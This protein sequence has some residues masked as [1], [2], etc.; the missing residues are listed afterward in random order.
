V[1]AN[2]SVSSG[3][4]HIWFPSDDTRGL[5]LGYK[6]LFSIVEINALYTPQTHFSAHPF[7]DSKDGHLVAFSIQKFGFLS[8]IEETKGLRCGGP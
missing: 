1:P 3:R 8:R 4:I 2:R 5:K 7:I 6:T